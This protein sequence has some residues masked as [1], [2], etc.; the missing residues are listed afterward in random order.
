MYRC[1]EIYWAFIVFK[2]FFIYYKLRIKFNGYQY[3]WNREWDSRMVAWYGYPYTKT[4]MTSRKDETVCLIE[5]RLT[6]KCD[7]GPSEKKKHG[8]VQRGM[9]ED[10]E[11]YSTQHF[12]LND[13][14][15]LWYSWA[16]PC[17]SWHHTL[18]NLCVLPFAHWLLVLNAL[19]GHAG[20]CPTNVT[21]NCYLL[22]Y[23][24]G[25]DG[26]CLH[27]S[28]Q[29]GAPGA[30]RLE[31]HTN[32]DVRVLEGITWVKALQVHHGAG[33]AFLLQLVIVSV[34]QF[35]WLH[36]SLLPP[37]DIGLMLLGVDVLGWWLPWSKAAGLCGA[38]SLAL[39]RSLGPHPKW[40][41]ILF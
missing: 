11:W 17:T 31:S 41:P 36:Q 28:A 5:W 26:D 7:V 10:V 18:H 25:V 23:I 12:N 6:Q 13:F 24:M 15:E 8:I 34:E 38:S 3:I 22:V 9:E 30:E 32:R 27:V 29:L 37:I 20:K 19:C 21:C 14:F 16:F 39:Q 35:E 1:L 40:D 33:H 4:T 2:I